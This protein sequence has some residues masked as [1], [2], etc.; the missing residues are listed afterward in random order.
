LK[1]NG[2]ATNADVLA[3]G[4]WSLPENLGDKVPAGAELPGLVAAPSDYSLT[5]W[6]EGDLIFRIDEKYSFQLPTEPV[7][8]MQLT[9]ESRS[10]ARSRIRHRCSWPT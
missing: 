4:E 7:D 5:F 9:L 6:F 1:G 8:H 3:Q 2:S 10:T